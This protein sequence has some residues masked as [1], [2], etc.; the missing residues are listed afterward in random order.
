[1]IEL[2]DCK[3]NVQMLIAERDELHKYK[4]GELPLPPHFVEAKER[5]EVYG[6]WLVDQLSKLDTDIQS[7]G[8]TKPPT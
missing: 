5:A 4:H 1:M 3:E 8:D 6:A 7:P 2:E